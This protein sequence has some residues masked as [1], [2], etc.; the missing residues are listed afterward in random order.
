MF[1]I[2]INGFFGTEYIGIT[3]ATEEKAKELVKKYN[4]QKDSP[5]IYYSYS[6]QG[7]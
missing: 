1:R 2:L 4:E 6:K 3:V 7:N 5:Y